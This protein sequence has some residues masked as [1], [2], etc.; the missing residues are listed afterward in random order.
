MIPLI[1]GFNPRQHPF[2]AHRCQSFIRANADQ[3]ETRIIAFANHA[4]KQRLHP[5]HRG[6]GRQQLADLAFH[7]AARSFGHTHSHAR[8]KRAAGVGDFGQDY[9]YH[10]RPICTG[11]LAS[12]QHGKLRIKRRVMAAKNVSRIRGKAVCRAQQ[13]LAFYR[14]IR[15]RRAKQITGRNCQVRHITKAQRPVSKGQIEINPFGQEIFNQ[16]RARGQRIRLKIGEQVQP[17]Y[18]ARR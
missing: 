1:I 13:R 6:G 2:H 9:G 8:L 12:I 14:Q 15:A 3:A 17:P 4:V 7:R 11:A 5:D 10:G 18:P 16:E